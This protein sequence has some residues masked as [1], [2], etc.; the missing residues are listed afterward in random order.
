MSHTNT[1]KIAL[2][3]GDWI[4][5]KNTLLLQDDIQRHIWTE[6]TMAILNEN[7][8]SLGESSFRPIHFILT[9]KIDFRKRA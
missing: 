5:Q 8:K 1:I 6:K 4:I 2:S 7:A 3:S 9:N